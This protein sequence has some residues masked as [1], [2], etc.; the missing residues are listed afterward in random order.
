[1]KVKK[2]NAKI[3][4]FDG[5]PLKLLASLLDKNLECDFEVCL[6]V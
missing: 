1:M 6:S 3:Q 2:F 5:L 4:I